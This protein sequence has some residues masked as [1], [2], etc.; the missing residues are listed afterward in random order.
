MR[1]EEGRGFRKEGDGGEGEKEGKKDAQKVLSYYSATEP[2]QPTRL[3]PD[4]APPKSQIQTDN[5]QDRLE[6]GS[7][8]QGSSMCL[9]VLGSV[10]V[11]GSPVRKHTGQLE[12][13]T[14]KIPKTI[15]NLTIM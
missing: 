3:T 10:S 14:F 7:S 9:A 5:G 15:L 8:K 1:S 12:I 13:I 4:Q 11:A 6:I 2:P